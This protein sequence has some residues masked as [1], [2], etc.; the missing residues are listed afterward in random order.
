MSYI[1]IVS[2]T[3][4]DYKRP[5]NTTR[6]IMAETLEDAKA[7][8]VT[9]YL[10]RIEGY[11]ARVAKAP[12]APAFFKALNKAFGFFPGGAHDEDEEQAEKEFEKQQEEGLRELPELVEPLFN[13]FQDNERSLFRGE[14]VPNFFSLTLEEDDAD[15]KKP[16]IEETF[17]DF[18]YRFEQVYDQV[19]D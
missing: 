4:D 12:E 5:V 9:E 16:D 18:F 17:K 11:E 8:A 15:F 2:S 6:R 14:Y 13:F 7:L 10:N 3:S 19:P 1:I